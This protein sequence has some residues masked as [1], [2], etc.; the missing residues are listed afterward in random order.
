MKSQLSILLLAAFCLILSACG[1][2][3]PVDPPFQGGTENGTGTETEPPVALETTM[4]IPGVFFDNA[5]ETKSVM[6]VSDSGISFTWAEGDKVGVFSSGSGIALFNLISGT[7]QSTGVFDGEGF[8]LTPGSTYYA[9]YPYELSGTD[10]TKVPLSFAGQVAAGDDDKTHIVQKDYLTATAVANS[11][12]KASF[13]FAHL[14]SFLRMKIAMPDGAAI[15]QVEYIP[16]YD[17]V[18][19]EMSVNLT[20]GA[21]ST[22]ASAVSMPV[23]VSGGTPARAGDP[24]TLWT[25]MPP[26]SYS[27]ETDDFAVVV[28]SGDNVYS[29]RHKGAAFNAGKAYSWTVTPLLEGS[30]PGY[31]FSNVTEK[32]AFTASAVPSGQYSGITWLGGNRYAVVHDKL[33]GGGIVFYTIDIDDS[34]AITSVS[35]EVAAGTSSS[36]ASGKDPEGIAYVSSTQK[37]FVSTEGDQSIREYDLEGYPTGRSITIPSDMAKANITSNKGFE[38]LTYNETTG[39]FWTV[40]ESPLKKDAALGLLRLQSFNSDL[41]AGERYLYRMDEPTKTSSGTKSYV[42]GVPAL[43]AMDDGRILVLEREV[44]VPDSDNIIELFGSFTKINIYAVNPQADGAGILRKTL[45]K[46]FSTSAINLNLA[47]YEGM[48]IGPTLSDGTVCLILIPDSQGGMD[49]LTKEYVKVITIK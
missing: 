17:P 3:E 29:A 48:C 7:G 28:R 41:E 39:M 37:L 11:N 14:E 43:A 44:W 4:T 12:G 20:T 35:Y 19:T 13:D 16:V 27:G 18:P 40:T 30:D 26:K 10:K 49:G 45:V 46:S 25:S 1:G 42:F 34:G 36:T 6:D 5:K 8:D 38:A 22:T 9:F 24:F 32:P 31:G 33:N 23:A 47:N 15:D 2:V 21:I